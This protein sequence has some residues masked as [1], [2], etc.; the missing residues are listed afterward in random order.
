MV[1]HHLVNIARSVKTTRSHM[2]L[3][4]FMNSDCRVIPST[5]LLIFL[6]IGLNDMSRVCLQGIEIETRSKLL[7]LYPTVM[8]MRHASVHGEN[9]GTSRVLEK[10]P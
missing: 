9:Y 1:V 8:C 6:D 10:L 2:A 5:A 4:C 3:P 7:H